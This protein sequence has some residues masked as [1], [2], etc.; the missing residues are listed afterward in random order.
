M[1]KVAS[2]GIIFDEQNRILF[3]HRTDYDLWNLPGGGVGPSSIELL[4][5]GKL[6]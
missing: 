4:Q 2:F 1:F 6:L 3:C 5:T